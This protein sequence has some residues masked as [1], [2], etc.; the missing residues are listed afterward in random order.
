MV[1]VVGLR[2]LEEL[3]SPTKED[4]VESKLIGIELPEVPLLKDKDN[5]CK[6]DVIFVCKDGVVYAHRLVIAN[7]SV[8]VGR[9]F[10]DQVSHGG[11]GFRD[12]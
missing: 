7:A 3:R 11:R 12:L 6:W 2:Y 4:D 1:S 5:P 8:Y 9:M 10:D